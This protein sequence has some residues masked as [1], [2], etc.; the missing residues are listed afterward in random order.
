LRYL[1][2]QRG[3][4]RYPLSQAQHEIRD[5]GV[6]KSANEGG[7]QIEYEDQDPRI[8]PLWPEEIAKNGVTSERDGRPL[9]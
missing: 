6:D 9:R 5:T 2:I 7:A 1:A 8:H 4:V 3:T